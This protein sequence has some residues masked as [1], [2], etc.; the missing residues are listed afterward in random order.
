MGRTGGHIPV[1]TK[2]NSGS[3]TCTLSLAHY[4][5][6][7]NTS[8]VLIMAPC[9]GGTARGNLVGVFARVTSCSAIPIVL[10]SIPSHAN[11]NLRPTAITTLTSRPG[12]MNLGTTDNGVS[13]V[14]R[15]TRLYNSGVTVCSN[16][17]SRAV[18]VVSLNNG[19]YVS[20]LSGLL[21]GRDTL[22][23]GGFFSN[24][25]GNTARVRLSCVPLVGTLFDRI[26]PVPMGTTVT[27]V[28]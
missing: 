11:I 2:T 8:T 21:P 16:G 15:A 23:Y 7:T 10:C 12:V 5:Y 18:P 6:R 1:V 25:V 3:A 24:S 26:G 19:K 4:T 17:S 14:T 13:G 27:G 9:C 20:I 28:N 22:V